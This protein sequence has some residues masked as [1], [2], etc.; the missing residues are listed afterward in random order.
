MLFSVLEVLCCRSQQI[1]PPQASTVLIKMT[2]FAHMP[3][4]SLLMRAL[5]YI[6]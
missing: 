4:R 3:A 6:A 5:H 1:F 2:R